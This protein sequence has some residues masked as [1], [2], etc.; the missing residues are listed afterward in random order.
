MNFT[1]LLNEI[2]SNPKINF[3]ASAITPLHIVGIKATIDKLNSQGI[4]LNGYVLNRPHGKTG[5]LDLQNDF[6]SSVNNI[7]CVPFDMCLSGSRIP[8]VKS[9]LFAIKAAMR[10]KYD[11]TIY[12]LWTK[13]EYDWLYL[14]DCLPLDY[15]V[16]FVIIDDGAGSY[17]SRFANELSLEYERV[18]RQQKL[19]PA[20]RVKAFIKVFLMTMY[21][22][23]LACLVRANENL[24]DN[25]IF[26]TGKKNQILGQN[27]S[28]VNSYVNAFQS[29]VNQKDCL[30]EIQFI[31]G[32]VLFNTQCLV[33]SGITDGIVDY[34]IYKKAIDIAQNYSKRVVVKPHP[35]ENDIEKYER[36]NADILETNYTQE[37]LLSVATNKP[38]CVVSIFSSTLLNAKGLFGIPAISLARIMLK[39]DISND[40]KSTLEAF[41][42][43]Y[44]NIIQFPS[45]FEEY[46]DIIKRELE[47][48]RNEQQ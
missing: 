10:K 42:G 40:L 41:I 27:D 4:V 26:V 31:D 19:T 15:R 1:D 22:N 7:N 8:F 47:R 43:Q 36:L 30:K 18:L 33:E 16:V 44:S 38:I 34:E 35:R 21:D 9:H 11:R 17:V 46:N 13:I 24:I 23:L 20:A 14:L 12:V 28:I 48:R 25:R 6:T 29:S 39:E 37:S 2:N 3:I 32:C 5:R 45:S